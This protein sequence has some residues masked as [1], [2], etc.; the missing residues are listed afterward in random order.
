MKLFV[1]LAFTLLF[2]EGTR[3]KN[4]FVPPPFYAPPVFQCY[5]K[6]L[7]SANEIIEDCG[8]S[9]NVCFKV[10]D[11]NGGITK[12]CAKQDDE[13][14]PYTC[15]NETQDVGQGASTAAK[16]NTACA[17]P[18][19]ATPVAALARPAASWPL[20]PRSC[21]CSSLSSSRDS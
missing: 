6:T 4:Y 1:L 15:Q 12:G 11:R 14:T 3:A 2:L 7:N 17:T 18:T 9:P 10:T 19:S 13:M 5:N 8:D 21:H 16:R 20:R